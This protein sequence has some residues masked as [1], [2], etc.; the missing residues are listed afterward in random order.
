MYY[1]CLSSLFGF[2]LMSTTFPRLGCNARLHPGGNIGSHP[3]CLPIG[4][5]A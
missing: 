4:Y 1:M 3:A 2:D 5:V